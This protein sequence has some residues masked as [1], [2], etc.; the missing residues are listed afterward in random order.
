MLWYHVQS[1]LHNSKHEHW[2]SVHAFVLLQFK[3]VF[4]SITVCGYVAKVHFKCIDHQF[5]HVYIH[6][7]LLFGN[8]NSCFHT[9]GGYLTKLYL[10]KLGQ[11]HRKA[12]NYVLICYFQVSVT[13]FIWR[14]IAYVLRNGHFLWTY[15][16]NLHLSIHF[17][18][19]PRLL[20]T[21]AQSLNTTPTV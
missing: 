1:P 16:K 3:P 10:R 21:S 14:Y 15:P 6:D 7:L 4:S 18:L 13:Y 9:T 11:I 20:S 17:W 5:T 12:Q 19:Q 2:S 8:T